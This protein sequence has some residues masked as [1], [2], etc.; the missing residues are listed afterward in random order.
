M[1]LMV[2][3]CIMKW[4]NKRTASIGSTIK[5][6]ENQRFS[7][8]RKNSQKWSIQ[9]HR[10][11]LCREKHDKNALCVWNGNRRASAAGIKKWKMHRLAKTSFF[12]N[13]SKSRNRSNPIAAC[14]KT[15]HLQKH[16]FFKSPRRM[17]SF[18]AKVALARAPFVFL[19]Q[20]KWVFKNHEFEK[21]RPGRGFCE[22]YGWRSRSFPQMPTKPPRESTF[23]AILMDKSRQTLP[24][25]QCFIN[26][27]HSWN[28][29]CV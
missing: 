16:T 26:V 10:W 14:V 21:V 5:P 29:K 7:C 8:K 27:H 20:E 17:A 2:Q 24:Q 13:F 25:H 6:N 12:Y 23:H 3:T 4:H 18:A 19:T 9:I 22:K 15:Q 28:R 1:E 11:K